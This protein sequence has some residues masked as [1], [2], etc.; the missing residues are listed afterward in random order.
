M[1]I[2]LL[3]A[4]VGAAACAPGAGAAGLSLTVGGTPPHILGDVATLKVTVT[5]TDAAETAGDVRV[6][7]LPVVDPFADPPALNGPGCTVLV[8]PVL[9]CAL[10][11]SIAPGAS[12]HIDI[13]ATLPALGP[14]A[15]DVAA[16]GDA[17]GGGVLS[18]G[19]VRWETTVQPKA[20]IRLDVS[21]TPP[22]TTVGAPVGITAL[23]SNAT[24]GGVA[25]DTAAKFAIPNGVEVLAQ[26]A[27]CTTSGAVL[28]CALGDLASPASAQRVIT[29]RGSQGG[30]FSVP[31]SA[32]WARPD[33][34]PV[35][36]QA[37]AGF[38]VDP[39]LPAIAPPLIVPPPDA[40]G[41]SNATEAPCGPPVSWTTCLLPEAG[42]VVD[43]P[44]QATNVWPAPRSFILPHP[45][46]S[47]IWLGETRTEIGRPLIWHD[48]GSGL[49]VVAA[50]G[51]FE[52][53]LAG[54]YAWECLVCAG[55][56]RQKL[57]GTMY[58]IGPRARATATRSGLPAT[59][60]GIPY[61]VDAS[62][63]F[64]TDQTPYAIVEYAFDFDDDGTYEQI[65]PS[66][67]ATFASA[68]GQHTVRVR[69]K[70]NQAPARYGDTSLVV[71]VQNA[72]PQ[73]TLTT[74][75]DGAHYDQGATV[76]AD[77]AC[78]D[79]DGQGD[80]SS[81]T[82]T[83]ADGAPIDTS[84][85][86]SKSFTVNAEDGSGEP[87]TK[88]V[89]YTVDSATDVTP[90]KIAVAVPAEGGTYL[91]G[92]RVLADYTCTDE[93]GP[94]DIVTCTGPVAAGA[95]IDTGTA[96]AKSFVV[97]ATDGGGN[98][99]SKT[100]NYTVNDTQTAIAPPA[101]G[102]SLPARPARTRPLLAPPVPGRRGA[103]T[104]TF[105]LPAAG[106]LAV[107]ASA[108]A[109]GASRTI[110]FARAARDVRAGVVRL[111]LTP[112]AAGRRLL[113]RKKRLGVRIRAAFT[114]SGGGTAVVLTRSTRVR[115]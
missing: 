66:P 63:S 4:L 101:V 62:G 45:G 59:G 35:D 98:T 99:R 13:T 40:F 115:E 107:T 61:D 55:I 72:K 67:G 37:Q 1:T 44:D 57:Q 36:T 88:T 90:P 29:V 28:T 3:A 76:L 24:A 103:L 38:A 52:F 70:D 54:K 93:D 73:I 43:W 46:L 14:M 100:V 42:A 18:S 50:S 9:S 16:Q 74:P 47:A 21:V 48:V 114:A 27:G 23:V 82:G 69:V 41:V 85:P 65:G 104:L 39:G 12:A 78:T 95:P 105:T 64:V 58:V 32:V 96:G 79:P 75:V 71:D 33:P 15:V 51:G 6:N 102:S 11:S 17:S 87:A 108:T 10:A 68:P 5:N 80:V 81:C 109:G 7:V 8:P 83:V 92:A 94:A 77:F 31:V 91:R 26:P 97:S 2:A 34:T 110:T 84:T 60:A 30:Q 106:R 86:G 49:P 56:E 89:A 113:A 22:T 112:T 20:D 111:K 53:P 19:A 25:Y